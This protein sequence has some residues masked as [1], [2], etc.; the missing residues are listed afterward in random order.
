VDSA[1]CQFP[2]LVK[3]LRCKGASGSFIQEGASMTTIS[4]GQAA[5]PRG[6][7]TRTIAAAIKVVDYRQMAAD[8]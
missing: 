7:G 1:R 3:F 5:R 8:I 4:L 6:L 2:S